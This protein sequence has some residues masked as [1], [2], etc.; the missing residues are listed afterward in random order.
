MTALHISVTVRRMFSVG[1][2]NLD[3]KAI[4]DAGT[5][6]GVEYFIVEQDES[7]EAD[8][9]DELRNSYNYI[10]ENFFE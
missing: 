1:S 6:C 7:Y 2:G 10:A 4:I 3:W 9:F 5:R 8:P